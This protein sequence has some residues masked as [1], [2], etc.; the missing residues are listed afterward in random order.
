MTPCVRASSLEWSFLDSSLL[1]L[2]I[3]TPCLLGAR[4][5][6]TPPEPP[7]PP[8]PITDGASCRPCETALH[9]VSHTTSPNRCQQSIALR[10]KNP[11]V[12]VL[13]LAVKWRSGRK[14]IHK[15]WSSDTISKLTDIK[16]WPSGHKIR[17]V[18]FA[19]GCSTMTQRART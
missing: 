8:L 14:L 12:V 16:M 15:M 18:L 10:N 4:E 9:A 17:F 3:S 2:C 7:H 19:P 11:Q 5:A 13:P 6:R 1:I